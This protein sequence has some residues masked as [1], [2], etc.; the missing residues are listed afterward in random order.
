MNNTVY[1]IEFFAFLSKTGHLHLKQNKI[2][3]SIFIIDFPF[4]VFSFVM[5]YKKMSLIICVTGVVSV[6]TLDIIFNYILLDDF[7]SIKCQI[8]AMRLIRNYLY[9]LL[10]LWEITAYNNQCTSHNE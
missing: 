9:T 7:D 2:S 8:S 5:H 3:F 4:S 1:Q 6:T 10:L